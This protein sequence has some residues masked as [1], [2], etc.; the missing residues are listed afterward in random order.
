MLSNNKSESK[1]NN[2][3]VRPDKIHRTPTSRAY[4]CRLILFS[5]ATSLKYD[6]R[7]T[8]NPVRQTPVHYITYTHT[9]L[10]PVNISV[11]LT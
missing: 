4:R 10:N 1:P 6:T 11:P 2:N 5:S 8:W 7:C 9:V 3:S